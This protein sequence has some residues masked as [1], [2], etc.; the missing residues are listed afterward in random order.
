MQ[1][2]ENVSFSFCTI[3]FYLEDIYLKVPSSDGRHSSIQKKVH[4]Y[5]CSSCRLALITGF[6]YACYVPLI[7]ETCRISDYAENPIY[8]KHYNCGSIH[9]LFFQC[10]SNCMNNFR[11]KTHN[12]HGHRATM[13][14]YLS[15]CTTELR[16]GMMD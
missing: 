4:Q 15:C 16:K 11:R 14:D 6:T 3:P 8:L 12:S 13:R 9:A 1:K 2:E 10:H 7:D 5:L